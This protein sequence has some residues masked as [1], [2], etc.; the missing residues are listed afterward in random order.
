[1]A[2]ALAAS[3][4]ADQNMYA[5]IIVNEVNTLVRILD[6]SVHDCGAKVTIIGESTV[7]LCAIT[8]H[9]PYIKGS[10]QQF[11]KSGA[12]SLGEEAALR[13]SY[14]SL[15]TTLDEII[16]LDA[17]LKERGGKADTDDFREWGHAE[18]GICS[19]ADH[20]SFH[21]LFWE[22]YHMSACVLGNLWESMQWVEEAPVRLGTL[23]APT[24][25]R[26]Y[27]QAMANDTVTD[28]WEM[29]MRLA[30]ASLQ[31]TPSAGETEIMRW[32]KGKE[33][34]MEHDRNVLEKVQMALSFAEEQKNI[35]RAKLSLQSISLG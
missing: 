2:T 14:H 9:E 19:D 29:A 33:M 18:K 20:I 22:A 26:D 8:Q 3:Q 34:L 32:E 6:V 10:V 13:H 28:E 15:K 31:L 11:G 5:N 1:M 25:M 4:D 12:S 35:L 24:T 16:T 7:K 17:L 23:S 30:F 27:R 21:S